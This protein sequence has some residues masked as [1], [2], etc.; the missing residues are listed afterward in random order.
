MTVYAPFNFVPLSSWV[1]EPSWAR[2]VT[3]D[4]PFADGL[5]GAIDIEIE[6]ETPLLVG[7]ERRPSAGRDSPTEVFP[8][9]LGEQYAIPPASLQ[10]CIRS[11]VET[12]TFSRF[13]PV[14]DRRFGVRDLDPASGKEIYQNRVIGKVLTGWLSFGDGRASWLLSPCAMKRI[15]F[16]ELR[17]LATE[18]RFNWEADSRERKISERAKK[19]EHRYNAL[20]WSNIGQRLERDGKLVKRPTGNGEMLDGSIVISG[21]TG[22]RGRRGKK[23]EFFFHGPE[24]APTPIKRDVIRDFLLIHEENP[25]WLLWKKRIDKGV[26]N[27]IPVFYITS[28]G[29]PEG[30]VVSFGLAFMFKLAHQ[31]S[32]H[33]LIANTSPRHLGTERYDFATM[34]F[35]APNRPLDRPGEMPGLKGRIAFDFA[36]PAHGTPPPR[37]IT[38]DIETVLSSPK[39]T[40]APIYVLQEGDDAKVDSRRGYAQYTP[41][42]SQPRAELAGRKRYPVRATSPEDIRES[43]PPLQKG[44]KSN[45]IL[46]PLQ[47]GAKL[48]TRLR[49][50][51]L[52]PVELGALIWALTWGQRHAHRH[53]LGMGKPLGMGRVVMRITGG[54]VIP[55][56]LSQPRVADLTQG[57]AWRWWGAPFEAHM[58]EQ[59]AGRSEVERKRRH[60]RG[61]DWIDSPQVRALLAMADPTNPPPHDLK[62]MPLQEFRDA[63]GGNRTARGGDSHYLPPYVPLRDLA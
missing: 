29:T 5:S 50:H 24:G 33:E 62:Y 3:H 38:G 13:G 11:V 43:F 37:V 49:F 7:G 35:G 63:K 55:N 41:T 39:A 44:A 45:S 54:A 28:D 60:D 58:Q 30:E 10:G 52:R 4:I 61:E 9:K 34:L 57:E 16:T 17:E 23:A 47:T 53:A 6:A 12:I 19:V 42:R 51:N 46:H 18:K 25:T 8:F 31:K 48:S 26:S 15:S 21:N 2:L 59:Y 1:Y 27:R 36:L 56:D 40:Y 20:G 32:T 14:D 22:Q